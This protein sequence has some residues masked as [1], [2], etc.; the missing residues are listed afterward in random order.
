MN[1]SANVL[2][3]HPGWSGY[4]TGNPYIDEWVTAVNR[5]ER[6]VIVTSCWNRKFLLAGAT[7]TAEFETELLGKITNPNTVVFYYY[8]P[9]A[10]NTLRL[11]NGFTDFE[12]MGLCFDC[13]VPR[14]SAQTSM[15]AS[16]RTRERPEIV[17]ITDEQTHVVV[18]LNTGNGFRINKALSSAPNDVD[19]NLVNGTIQK[20]VDGHVSMLRRMRLRLLGQRIGLALCKPPLRNPIKR[21][22]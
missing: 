14:R 22:C 7:E 11:L 20:A 6:A 4:E 3:V 13:C 19:I 8:I 12:A 17:Q 21:I 1:A 5:A 9:V 2:L 15:F 10:A 16:G 18:R